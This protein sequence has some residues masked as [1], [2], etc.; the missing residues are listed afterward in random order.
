MLL[1]Q[2]LAAP[3][4]MFAFSGVGEAVSPLITNV[5]PITGAWIAVVI[6]RVGIALVTALQSNAFAA[7]PI[8]TARIGLLLAITIVARA[9][10][11]PFQK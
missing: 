8:M 1:P 3:G 9:R 11:H 7:F 2:M 5:V 4:G 6:Y 10:H